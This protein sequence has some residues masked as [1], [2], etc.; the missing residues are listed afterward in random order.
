MN[1]YTFWIIICSIVCVTLVMLATIISASTDSKNN[2]EEDSNMA[3]EYLENVMRLKKI[4][5]DVD[6]MKDVIPALIKSSSNN[7]SD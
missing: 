1:E 5:H 2:N 4:E 6:Y 7:L 3:S